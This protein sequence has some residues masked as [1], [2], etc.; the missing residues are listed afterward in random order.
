MM[1]QQFQPRARTIHRIQ[2]YADTPQPNQ[3]S[4]S[5]GFPTPG[6]QLTAQQA[7]FLAGAAVTHANQA[8]QVASHAANAAEFYQR[9]AMQVREVAQA[10]IA[11]AQQTIQSIVAQAKAFVAE[12]EGSLG[13]VVLEAQAQAVQVTEDQ[14]MQAISAIQI[15][16]NRVNE[17]LRSEANVAMSQAMTT[18][19]QQKSEIML[20]R[21]QELETNRQ[22]AVNIE[23]CIEMS[24]IMKRQ[25][26]EIRLLKEKLETKASEGVPF[27]SPKARP[28]AIPEHQVTPSPVQ[29]VH[30]LISS[31]PRSHGEEV[32][33]AVGKPPGLGL[34]EPD[35]AVTLQHPGGAGTAAPSVNPD[36]SNVF[37]AD[38]LHVSSLYPT[39]ISGVPSAEAAQPVA[40][41]A[42]V[43]GGCSGSEV[44]VGIQTQ[45]DQVKKMMVELA[46]S[47]A[48]ISKGVPAIAAPK[49]CR[50][51][52][53]LPQ[54]LGVR[55]L[56][57]IYQ[58]V[59]SLIKTLHHQVVHHHPHHPT[60]VVLFIPKV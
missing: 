7:T 17:N 33:G 48:T 24:E 21:E 57:W 22:Q 40:P 16:A 41:K 35:P 11:N 39:S 45:I 1:L 51:Q 23:R 28:P 34:N 55:F 2:P 58:L 31:P 56:N 47:V 32:F 20:L 14:A 5:D 15:E 6:P 50:S 13:Q 4:S 59:V 38:P 49:K 54:S 19:N 26:E 36:P 46:T 18:I 53:L 42:F 29:N 30:V 60:A 3:S 9:E 43:P 52:C 44:D 27:G 37:P 25:Q 10:E 12:R 8:S